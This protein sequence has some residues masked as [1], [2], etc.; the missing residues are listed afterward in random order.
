MIDLNKFCIGKHD[1]RQNFSMPFSD[2]NYTY[3]SNMHLIIKVPKI[4]GLKNLEGYQYEKIIKS[5]EKYL[6][7]LEDLS[8]QPIGDLPPLNYMNCSTCKG[9]GQLSA[10]KNFSECWGRGEFTFTNMFNNYDINRK[11]CDGNGSVKDTNNLV[12]C[13]ECDGEKQFLDLDLN[14]MTFTSGGTSLDVNS[15]YVRMFAEL[16]G[17]MCAVVENG[18]AIRFDG[19]FGFIMRMIKKDYA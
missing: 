16:P 18:L 14:R 7:G 1:R 10:D 2:A 5:T 11:S 12:P 15:A 3:A 9:A 13:I 8:Y 19:G 4:D 17:A 6:L